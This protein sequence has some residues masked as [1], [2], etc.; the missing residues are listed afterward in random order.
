MKIDIEAVIARKRDERERGYAERLKNARERLEKMSQRR[1]DL[2]REEEEKLRQ[3]ATALSDKFSKYQP[4]RLHSWFKFDNWTAYEGLLILCDIDPDR[5]PY[6]T[7]GEPNLEELRPEKLV[8]L[9]PSER[10]EREC[11]QF[12]DGIR[13]LAR[14]TIEIIGASSSEMLIF[15]RQFLYEK[16]L[17]IWNSG[18]HTEK[19]YPPKYF[20]NWAISKDIEIPWLDWAKSHNYY[21]DKTLETRSLSNTEKN[22][23]LVLVAA[24]AKQCSISPDDRNSASAIGR[25]VDSLGASVTT[26]TIRKHLDAIPEALARRCR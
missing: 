6:N 12:L 21:G 26:E 23:L 18:N 11:I 5:I 25:M 1:E 15:E 17:R 24:L 22:T 7:N 16:R 10:F 20:I 4:N 13:P 14:R 8:D 19:R 2:I 9:P 3:H